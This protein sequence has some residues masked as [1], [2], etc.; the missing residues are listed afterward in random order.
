MLLVRTWNFF[1]FSCH[2]HGQPW[3]KYNNYASSVYMYSQYYLCTAKAES[4]DCRRAPLSI[5][6]FLSDSTVYWPFNQE[7]LQ[8]LHFI[9]FSRFYLFVWLCCVKGREERMLHFQCFLSVMYK[10]S[11]QVRVNTLSKKKN[12]QLISCLRNPC[13]TDF[14]ALAHT[15]VKKN[16]VQSL[17]TWISY[18]S[19]PSVKDILPLGSL[20]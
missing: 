9:H 20:W 6:D 12:S 18:I 14:F 16:S 1:T 8:G 2:P 13:Y 5:I 3:T 10:V 11:R 4:P 19:L 7:M 15:Q 17:Q